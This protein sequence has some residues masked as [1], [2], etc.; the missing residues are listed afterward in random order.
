M[1]SRG[2]AKPRALPGDAPWLN[3]ASPS[4]FRWDAIP[5]AAPSAGAATTAPRWRWPGAWRASVAVLHAGDPDEPALRGYLALG[6]P[7]VQTIDVPRDRDVL[8]PLAALLSD[9]ALVLC[10]S[11]GESGMGSGLL[12]ICWRSVWAVRYCPTCSPPS[13]PAARSGRGSFCPG[14]RRD[15]EADLPALLTVH[16]AAPFEPR[17]AYARERAGRVLPVAAPAQAAPLADAWRI[18]PAD[19]RRAS[20]PRPNAAP[21]AT[22]C[23]PR[24]PWPA[25]A[26]KSFSTAPRKTKRARCLPI[27][28][29]T[30]WLIT[31]VDHEHHRP[32]FPIPPARGR[33]TARP[34]RQPRSGP[35]PGRAVLLSQQVFDLDMEAIFARHWIHVAVEPDIPEPGDYITVD[36]GRHSVVI[37]RDDDQQIRAFHNVCRH[38]GSRLCQEQQGSVGNLVCPITSGPIRWMASSPTPNTWAPASTSARTDSSP[39]MCKAWPACSS[40][41]WRTRRRPTSPGCAT[42]SNP[43]CC[44][45]I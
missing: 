6:A 22:G 24:P 37:V 30:T 31:E 38:R 42:K 18:E 3:R 23:W 15:M 44:R 16:P 9:Y 45:T 35:Q 36:V 7:C 19:A 5:S 40:S 20:W 32:A 29:L 39:C 33:R 17:Y 25:G 10:G 21:A 13:W 12:P 11:R 8:D 34:D 26:A 41:A 2:P 14:R 4:W 1:K 28:A 43:I 27:C